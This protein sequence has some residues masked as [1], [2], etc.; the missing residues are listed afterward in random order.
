MNGWKNTLNM[1]IVMEKPMTA[2]AVQYY[3]D[4]NK[5]IDIR[6]DLWSDSNMFVNI[7]NYRNDSCVGY[8]C[9]REELKGLADFIYETIGEKK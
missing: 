2:K 6:V 4:K 8:T 9:S 5:L 3:L 7:Y 1:N